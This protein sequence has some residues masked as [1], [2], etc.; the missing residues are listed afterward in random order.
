MDQRTLRYLKNS[1]HVKVGYG[2]TQTTSQRQAKNVEHD[3]EMTGAGQ[4]ATLYQC[5]RQLVHDIE[6]IE[7]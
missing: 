6:G 5:K 2:Q 7:L 3:G 4:M 1:D